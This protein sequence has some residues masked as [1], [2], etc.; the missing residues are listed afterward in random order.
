MLHPESD[1]GRDTATLPPQLSNNA[2]DQDMDQANDGSSSN[3]SDNNEKSNSGGSSYSGTLISPPLQQQQQQP[4][5]LYPTEEDTP[6]VAVATHSTRDGGSASSDDT[7]S[8][9]RQLPINKNARKAPPPP[10]DF[11]IGPLV[12][13]LMSLVALVFTVVS[14]GIPWYRLKQY[15]QPS[16]GGSSYIA[17]FYLF[18]STTQLEGQ[19]KVTTHAGDLCPP[20]RRRVIVMQ[21][22][23]I[24]S[25]AMTL[26]AFVLSVA[27][28]ILE[29]TN[30]AVYVAMLV[31]AGAAVAS[32]TILVSFNFNV[33][34]WSFTECGEG[35][36][37]HSQL[38][39]PYAGF[40]L[41]VTA[42]V[43]AAFVGLIAPNR[44][45]IP[46]DAR[47]VDR[48]IHIYTVLAL[49]A[50][51]FAVV[52]CPI[53]HWFYKDIDTRQ[54]TDVLLWREMVGRFDWNTTAPTDRVNT[55][56]ADLT[57]GPLR[58]YF[59]AA[60]AF[61]I[62]SICCNAAAGL[63]GMLLWN[64]LVGTR[65]PALVFCYAGCV[66]TLVQMGLELRIY[67][68]SWCDGAYAYRN[69][70]FILSSGFA[71]VATAFCVMAVA[72][73]FMTTAYV[74]TE[75]YFPEKRPAKT[76]K[77]IAVEEMR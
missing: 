41:T 74:L 22:F 25:S 4:F 55:Y 18:R 27:N 51:L 58:Q 8:S 48:S 17:D 13:V 54:A 32:L 61:S 71:L 9:H 26:M 20:V 65:L 70:Y 34:L 24:I 57:C 68:G 56:V 39:E 64:H 5:D 7:S 73:F 21:A 66:M 77:Q 40:G 6:D 19:P 63:L 2:V 16:F 67:Y 10:R 62:I 36:S 45:I 59:R 47:T 30:R 50:M 15:Q 42:W 23:S 76:A 46:L 60:Q 3:N 49:L 75:R 43:L 33:Y 35:S 31:F 37:F 52:A 44:L 1:R 72:C 12:V 29:K 69:R 11:L 53:S 14:I 28:F 38:Y